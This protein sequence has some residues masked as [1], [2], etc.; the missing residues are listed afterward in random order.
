MNY[1]NIFVLDEEAIEEPYDGAECE[2]Q[3]ER[4]G[5]VFHTPRLDHPFLHV[6]KGKTLL[7]SERSRLNVYGISS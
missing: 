3:G 6:G 2:R 1:R 5:H 7:G 4:E